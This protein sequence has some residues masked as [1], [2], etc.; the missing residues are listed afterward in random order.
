MRDSTPAESVRPNPP[1]FNFNPLRFC[2]PPIQTMQQRQSLIASA[3]YFRA[4]KRGFRAG[5]DLEDWLAA[6]AE[7]DQHLAD[8]RWRNGGPVW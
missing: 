1:I 7:V 4:E 3:A 2:S 8:Q 6:E 5:H